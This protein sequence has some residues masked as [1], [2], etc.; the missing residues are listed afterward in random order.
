MGARK[1]SISF[2]RGDRFGK[3]TAL[4]SVTF[5]QLKGSRL[6]CEC[7]CGTI[8]SVSVSALRI[9]RT[10]S[11]GCTLSELVVSRFTTHGDT[12]TKEYTAWHAIQ[13]RC[14]NKNNDRYKDYGGRGISVCARWKASYLDFLHDVGRAPSAAHSIDRIDNNGDYEPGNV[15]WATKKQQNRN[16]RLVRFITF[17]GER[18]PLTEWAEILGINPITLRVRIDHYKMPIEEAMSRKVDRSAKKVFRGLKWKK[19]RR[20]KS[21]N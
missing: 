16:T 3:W 18:R 2:A 1:I 9:G 13:Q 19:R 4:E 15:R 14:N 10:N 21:H 20:S 17:R 8:R 6:S 11:C 7:D 12:R 5:L